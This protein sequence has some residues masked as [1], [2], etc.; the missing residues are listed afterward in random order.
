LPEDAGIKVATGGDGFRW[1]S[2]GAFKLIKG[3][4]E[5][6]VDPTGMNCVDIGASTGGFTQVLLSRGASRVVAVD[7][8]YGQ[9]AWVLRN[10]P[11]VL[12][13][14]RKN[15]RYLTIGDIGAPAGLITADASFISLRL[16]LPNMGGL[17][18]EGGRIIALVKPQFE[19]G[20]W[21]VGKGVVRDPLLH[22]EALN[23]VASSARDAGLFLEGAV[24]S[25]IRGPEGNIEFIFLLSARDESH[26]QVD[27]NSLV[28][29]AHEKI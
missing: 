10:D 17:L 18:A 5:W 7:V 19:V 14:E 21:N 26:A 25:P 4:D 29:E 24:Y 28:R 1:V 15:A 16:L 11:R 27:F 13:L 23:A 8:G 6:G 9:L 12:L 3:L 22:E 2:R 20:R